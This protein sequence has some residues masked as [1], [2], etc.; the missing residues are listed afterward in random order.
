MRQRI[1][2]CIEYFCIESSNSQIV[3]KRDDFVV[4][5]T[6]PMPVETSMFILSGT[7]RSV[8]GCCKLAILS[9]SLS[10]V[11]HQRIRGLTCDAGSLINLLTTTIVSSQWSNI[12][13]TTKYYIFQVSSSV[14]QLCY[15]FVH[16]ELHSCLHSNQ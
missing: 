7:N 9:D 10:R 6:D 16:S 13:V 3:P 1:F 15:I 12:I 11:F 2:S 5:Q 4:D 8:R 14:L